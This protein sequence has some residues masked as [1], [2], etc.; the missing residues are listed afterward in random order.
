M[1]TVLVPIDFSEPSISAF[2]FALDIAAKSGGTL[3]LLHV[4]TPP[5]LGGLGVLK[6]PSRRGLKDVAE[7][8]YERLLSEFKA[9]N[10]KITTYVTEGGVHSAIMNHLKNHEVDVVAMGTRGATGMREWVIGSNTEK[11]VRTSPVPVIAVKRY[12]ANP[13]KNIVFPNALDTE[14]QEDLVMKVKALQH[15]F[16]ARLYV[17]WIN[18]PALKEP[19]PETRRR[20]KAFVERFMLKD[21]SINIF[22]Y[23]DEE[24]GI[25]EFTKQI[26]GDMIA[27]G[28]H[29]LTGIAHLIAG[30][31][32]EDVVNH[33]QYPIWT[34]CT[35]SARAYIT[36]KNS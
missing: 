26:G 7:K 30:S 25:L 21:Y 20:L 23:T 5:V 10:I 11:M 35:K 33:L 28:T 9:E 29:G 2:R 17:I 1:K 32:T 34:Y 22:N 16:G 27:M 15:F 6:R 18:T 24:A 13:V 36:K 3:H 19:E 4:A 8:K 31:V 12:P 14:N